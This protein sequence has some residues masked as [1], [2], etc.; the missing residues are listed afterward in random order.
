MLIFS[1]WN[2][3]NL[4]LSEGLTKGSLAL[5]FMEKPPETPVVSQVLLAVTQEHLK[6]NSVFSIL[7]VQFSIV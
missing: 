3:P 2:H 6:E 5:L 1:L 7:N 4:A